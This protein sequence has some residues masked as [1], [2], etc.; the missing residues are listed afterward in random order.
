MYLSKS[1]K[2][3]KPG[4]LLNYICQMLLSKATYNAFNVYILSSLLTEKILFLNRFECRTVVLSIVPYRLL[5]VRSAR[6]LSARSLFR[7]LPSL[8]MSMASC[9]ELS[10]KLF[11][12]VLVTERAPSL[13][14]PPYKRIQETRVQ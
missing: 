14:F 11:W 1:A 5:V 12:M 13:S 8:R 7:V 2:F 6:A 9:L 10:K 3:I 4:Q